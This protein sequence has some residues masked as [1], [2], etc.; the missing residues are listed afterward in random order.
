MALSN[1]RLK[2]TV[3]VELFTH[4]YRISGT[5]ILAP[6]L[7]ADAIYNPTTAYVV[8]EDAYLSPI[9]DPAAIGRY[10]KML[11]VQKDELDFALTVNMKD[12]LR[13]DQRYKRSSHKYTISLTV[14]FFEVTGEVY[15]MLKKFDP[16]SYLGT[17]AGSFISLFNATASSMFD[18][19]ITYQGGVI[20]VNHKHIGSIGEQST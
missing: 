1:A 7:F 2:K 11:V 4:G 20:L 16:R 19:N 15:S 12:G 6:H 18:L 3:A 5:Y 8:L 13:R 14:P 9:T 10:Y 17:E